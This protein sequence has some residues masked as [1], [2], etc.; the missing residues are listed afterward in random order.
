MIRV[1]EKTKTASHGTT[2]S[3][4]QLGRRVN[5]KA[6][7][8]VRK[9]REMRERSQPKAAMNY[10]LKALE[11]DP[12]FV[13]AYIEAGM[14]HSE[15]DDHEQAIFAFQKAAEL[16]PACVLA[17]NNLAIELIKLK[18]YSDAEQSARRALQLDRT[19]RSMEYALGASLGYQGRNPEEALKYLRRAAAEYPR[20]RLVAAK[21]LWENN[22]R[23]EAAS[24]LKLYLRLDVEAAERAQI[25]A[26]LARAE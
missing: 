26:W 6:L 14:I 2:V 13:D 15:M 24:E 17:H 11:K 12:G 10:V 16:D 8:E 18:R 1:P 19:R 7:S 4:N 22:Q 9:E 20:A 25:E 3:V 23:G 5:G 21:V